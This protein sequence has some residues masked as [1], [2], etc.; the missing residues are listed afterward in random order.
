MGDRLCGYC[1]KPDH[2]KN[3]CP[4]RLEQ[5]DI[6]R[7]FIGEQRKL[8]QEILIANGIGPGAIVTAYD[9]WSGEEVACIVSALEP[10]DYGV[11][12]RIVKYKKQVRATIPILGDV[13]P[14]VKNDLIRFVKKSKISIPVF[15]LADS[16]RNMT[17][18]FRLDDLKHTIVHFVRNVYRG[19]DFNKPSTLLCQSDDTTINM[20]HIMRPTI[21]LHDRLTLNKET[22]TLVPPIL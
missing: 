16:S 17:A 1:R 13:V 15:S 20:D 12:Y 22:T 21:Q 2:N 11:D 10:H 6:I 8:S 14:D 9:P 3:K 7:R 4:M 18:E 5:I 19:W